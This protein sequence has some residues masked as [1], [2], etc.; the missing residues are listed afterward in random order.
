MERSTSLMESPRSHGISELTNQDYSILEWD[1]YLL[2]ADE[3][4]KK[5][6]VTNLHRSRLLVLSGTEDSDCYWSSGSLQFNIHN[7]HRVNGIQGG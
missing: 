7:D 6:D 3:T 1:N 4:L 5:H 2:K